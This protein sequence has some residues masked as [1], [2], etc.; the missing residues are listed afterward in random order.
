MMRRMRSGLV[1]GERD[2]P[3]TD[4]EQAGRMKMPQLHP[5]EEQRAEHDEHED[6]RGAEVLPGEDGRDHERADRHDGMNTCRH[7]PSSVC[8]R[9]RT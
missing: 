3:P 7:S 9:N 5:G 8:L 4:A 6:H 1:D 2:T